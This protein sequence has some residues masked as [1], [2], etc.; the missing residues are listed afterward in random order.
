MRINSHFPS[1]LQLQKQRQQELQ[2]QHQ[3]QQQHQQELQQQHQHHYQHPSN[4]RNN[5][6]AHR[7]PEIDDTQH[8][9]PSIRPLPIGNGITNGIATGIDA[10]KA[11]SRRQRQG[12]FVPLTHNYQEF[13]LQL[14]SPATTTTTISSTPRPITDP[15]TP[16]NQQQQPQPPQ[17]QASNNAQGVIRHHRDNDSSI[18]NDS[19]E[20]SN[21]SHSLPGVKVEIYPGVSQIFRGAE[22]TAKA[23]KRNFVEGCTCLA[24]TAEYSCIADAAFVICPACFVVNPVEG[25]RNKSNYND[26]HAKTNTTAGGGRNIE[27]W[28][29]GMGF[30]SDN[31]K[32]EYFWRR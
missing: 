10:T 14:S 7:P 28:G 12:A 31:D 17:F 19:S 1:Q 27:R 4:P 21:S 6:S 9:V 8:S 3:Q 25:P 32:G 20:P 16:T 11:A 15:Q 29:V 22:E 2:D 26:I 18:E 30:Y 13:D 23:A 24:C 5:Q